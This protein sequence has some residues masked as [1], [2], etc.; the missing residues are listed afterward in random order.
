MQLNRYK[1][2][3]D[4]G[5]LHRWSTQFRGS[6]PT[7]PYMEPL[8]APEG[9]WQGL[10]AKD[11]LITAGDDEIFL[12]DIEEMARRL[13]AVHPKTKI[14]VLEDETHNHMVME[15]TLREDKSETR[16]TF[17]KWVCSVLAD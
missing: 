10:P 14:C 2:A 3:L 4:A 11:V 16:L 15:L 9:W 8:S 6:A 12:D 17:E 1:D 5:V 7:D 13:Q